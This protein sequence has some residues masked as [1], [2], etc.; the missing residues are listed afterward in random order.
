MTDEDRAFEEMIDKLTECVRRGQRVVGVSPPGT[1]YPDYWPDYTSLEDYVRLMRILSRILGKGP[2]EI[3]AMSSKEYLEALEK[4]PTPLENDAE[5]NRWLYDVLGP[6]G[7][8][9]MM[10]EEGGGRA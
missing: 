9:K 2:G 3:R 5:A 10:V 6:E 7:F 4:A 1:D 8:G